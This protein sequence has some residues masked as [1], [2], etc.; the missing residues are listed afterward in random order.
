MFKN[1]QYMDC[2]GIARLI[3]VHS[4][5]FPVPTTSFFKVTILD[6]SETGSL[7]GRPKWPKWTQTMESY[8]HFEEPG[9]H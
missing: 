9:A 1:I 8:G 7:S 3:H 4:L 6:Q 5:S 2:W